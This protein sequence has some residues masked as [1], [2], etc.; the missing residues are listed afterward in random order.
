MCICKC[1]NKVLSLYI[2]VLFIIKSDWFWELR[3]PEGKQLCKVVTIINMYIETLD[4]ILN[5]L[6]NTQ[7]TLCYIAI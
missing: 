2:V 6:G 4:I 5:Q 1:Y 7:G 3:E